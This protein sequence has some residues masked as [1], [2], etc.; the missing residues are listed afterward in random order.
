MLLL[1]SSDPAIWTQVAEV[2]R[3]LA[4]GRVP[5]Q[6]AALAAALL[7]LWVVLA[8][9]SYSRAAAATDR[10]VAALTAA[11][12]E[13]DRRVSELQSLLDATR[14]DTSGAASG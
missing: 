11:V 9:G 8:G 2:K 5:W 1:A 3:E 6:L 12:A 7:L 10:R 13:G 14:V 4:A